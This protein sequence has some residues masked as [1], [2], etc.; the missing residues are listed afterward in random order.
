M[1]NLTDKTCPL[2]GN[3]C[4]LKGC[5]FFNERLD[6]CEISILNYNLYQLKEHIKAQL[7]NAKGAGQSTAPAYPRAPGGSGY[8]LPVR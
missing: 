4:L 1:H 7:A 6:G 5:T 8:P 2:M 3:T